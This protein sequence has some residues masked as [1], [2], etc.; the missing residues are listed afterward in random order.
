MLR[1][2]FAHAGDGERLAPL[3][4]RRGALTPYALILPS[5]VIMLS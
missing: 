3:Q 4:F 2:A 1:I 5:L